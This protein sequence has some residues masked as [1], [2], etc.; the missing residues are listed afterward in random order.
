TRD[1]VVAGSALAVVSI[2]GH[3][4][5]DY[6]RA[7]EAVEALWIAAQLHGLAVQ[8]VSPAFLYAHEDNELVSLTPTFPGELRS[9]Q[10]T[11]RKLIGA[12]PQEAQALVLRFTQAPPPSVRSRRQC[13]P[14]QTVSP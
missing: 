13:P 10:Y 2:A 9:L 5:S 3:T 1:R 8:P 14:R 12:G 7:G 6:A 11:F 4:L